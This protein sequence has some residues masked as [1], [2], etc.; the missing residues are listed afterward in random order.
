MLN[1]IPGLPSGVIGFEASG[2][3]EVED[4]RD[5]LFP[6]VQAAAANGDVRIV[7]VMPT[8]EGMSG[9]ALWQDIT[10]QRSTSKRFFIQ[11]GSLPVRS[12]A[13]AS[14]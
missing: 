4:Y 12:L 13:V 6:A 8:F 14:S 3:I 7:L 5:V 1:E 11:K 9:G 2:K 10:G